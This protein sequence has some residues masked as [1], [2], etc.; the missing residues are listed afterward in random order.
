M[1]YEM[2]KE[3][4]QDRQ[5][6]KKRKKEELELDNATDGIKEQ[7]IQTLQNEIAILEKQ[8]LNG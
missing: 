5:E 4:E 7:K 2:Q 6:K 8:T 1:R 3:R